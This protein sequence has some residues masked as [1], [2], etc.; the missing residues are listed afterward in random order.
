MKNFRELSIRT[1]RTNLARVGVEMTDEV[2]NSL[3]YS[4]LKIISRKAQKAYRL[5]LEVDGIIYKPSAPQKPAEK[6]KG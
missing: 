4:E 3:T 6:A 5:Y 2:F 1:I